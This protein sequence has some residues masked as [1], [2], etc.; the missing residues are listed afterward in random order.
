MQI[1]SVEIGKDRL[2]IIELDRD[3]LGG[4]ESQE[5]RNAVQ[6]LASK[7]NRKLVFDF[8]GAS[9][10]NSMGLG[11]LTSAYVTYTKLGGT[12]ALCNCGPNVRTLLGLTRV[13]PLFELCGNREEALKFLS[14]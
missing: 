3:L 2:A 5:V 14:G 10:I 1:H 8:I 9:H 7:G 6:E 4:P 13:G 11:V 12:I